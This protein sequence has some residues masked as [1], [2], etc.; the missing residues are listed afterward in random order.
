MSNI[1]FKLQSSENRTKFISPQHNT[2]PNLLVVCL[3]LLS[4]I[5]K[6]TMFLKFSLIS[7]YSEVLS[8][9]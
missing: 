3:L 9:K 8:G 1:E 2:R 5:V 4:I 7:C 6:Q